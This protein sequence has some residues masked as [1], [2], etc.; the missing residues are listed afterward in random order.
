M[1][2]PSFSAFDTAA[3]SGNNKELQ[4]LIS[5]TPPAALKIHPFLADLVAETGNAEILETLCTVTN[6]TYE[7][8]CIPTRMAVTDAGARGQLPV[9]EWGL[10]TNIIP[11]PCILVEAAANGHNHVV[12]YVLRELS[13][14]C[15]DEDLVTSAV[16]AATE[17][18]HRDIAAS[19]ISRIAAE[20]Q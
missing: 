17:N 20:T 9:V 8:P 18:G 3:L 1:T 11:L 4:R 7:T 10:D 16:F 19:I 15:Y 2:Q 12:D 13:E 5:T 6:P 14:F